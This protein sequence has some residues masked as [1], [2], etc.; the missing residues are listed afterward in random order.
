[1]YRR[2]HSDALG[3]LDTSP[4]TFPVDSN[5]S[6][7]LTYTAG[8]TPVV[9]GGQIRLLSP[10]LFSPPNTLRSRNGQA[11]WRPGF[12]EIV[13]RPADVELALTVETPP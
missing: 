3:R 13:K 12:T 11:G 4:V 2:I 9:P 10:R 1:M 8:T 6:F 7:T 5:Q